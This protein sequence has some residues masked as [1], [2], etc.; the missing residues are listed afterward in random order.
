MLAQLDSVDP[1]GLRDLLILLLALATP[2]AAWVG[3][4]LGRRSVIRVEPQPL[5]VR[6]SRD[7]IERATYERDQQLIQERVAALE[8]GQRTMLAEI[9]GRLE[10]MRSESNQAIRRVH[11]R[12]DRMPH[13]LIALLRN[14]GV[15]HDP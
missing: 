10:L 1:R 2:T 12:M 3:L 7:V 6:P 11:E 5:E 14:T 13:E 15:I 8:A 9:N 4:L